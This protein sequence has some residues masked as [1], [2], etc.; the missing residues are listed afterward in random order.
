M[1]SALTIAASG[2]AAAATWFGSAASNLAN[3]QVDGPV[4]ATPPTQP[5]PQGPG[6]VYQATVVLQQPTQNGGVSAS[7]APTLPSYR[8]AYDPASPFA[9]SAGAIA[10]PNVDMGT[11]I[12]AMMQARL[13]FGA[14]IQSFKAAA[15]MTQTLFDRIA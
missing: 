3:M 6:S 7:L 9:N 15:R 13:A 1:D 2:M 8:I 4:P 5:V 14:N 10:Q 11:E 12:V